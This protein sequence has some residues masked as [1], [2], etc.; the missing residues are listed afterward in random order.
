MKRCALLVPVVL[1]AMSLSSC[2]V[3]FGLDDTA[4]PTQ[5]RT[6]AEETP[7]DS[8]DVPVQ[9]PLP[10]DKPEETQVAPEE[11]ALPEEQE[12]A[13]PPEQDDGESD[14]VPPGLGEWKN[15]GVDVDGASDPDLATLED[16]DL[17]EFLSELTGSP[18]PQDGCWTNV[19]VTAYQTTGYAVGSVS[20]PECGDGHQVIWAK[21]GG[22]WKEVV[23]WQEPLPC[24]DIMKHGVPMGAPGVTC[25]EKGEEHDY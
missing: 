8:S 2:S 12:T 7:R 15:V 21:Q 3:I 20:R 16:Q 6:K 13:P 9:K 24:E 19:H 11:T 1:A 4:A 17:A 22:T 14:E 10:A 5:T 25:F 23:G 18:D